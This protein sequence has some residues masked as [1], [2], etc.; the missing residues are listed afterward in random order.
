V[1]DVSISDEFL[2]TSLSASIFT[3]T[4]LHPVINMVQLNTTTAKISDKWQNSLH[5]S[6]QKF[7]NIHGSVR[8]MFHKPKAAIGL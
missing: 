5:E 7:A 3:R 6:K 1:D 4:E 8:R 2:T